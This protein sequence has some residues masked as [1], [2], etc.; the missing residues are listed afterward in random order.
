[1]VKRWSWK[2]EDPCSIPGTH[3]QV[4]DVVTHSCNLSPWKAETGGSMWLTSLPA[5]PNPR[6]PS[7]YETPVSK[8]GDGVLKM[9][10]GVVL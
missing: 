1:M 4:S 5:Q 2:D 9:T 8:K 6:A 7:Q 10:P 3:T